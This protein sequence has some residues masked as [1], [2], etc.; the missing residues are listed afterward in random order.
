MLIVINRETKIFIK[1]INERS[2]QQQQITKLLHFLQR[3]GS[4][5]HNHNCK[6]KLEK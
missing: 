2:D 3:T 6:I 4:N 5:L 1:K